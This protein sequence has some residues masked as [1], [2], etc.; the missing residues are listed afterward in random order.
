MIPPENVIKLYQDDTLFGY[1]YVEVTGQNIADFGRN[2]AGDQAVVVRSLDQNL[3]A[4]AFGTGN[5]SG[6][7][8]ARDRLIN[9]IIV[10]TLASRLGKSSFL[11]DHEEFAADAFSILSRARRENKRISITYVASDQMVHFR[12][13]GSPGYGTSVL[14]RVKFIAKLYIGAI[15]NAFMRN[16]IR[17]PEKLVWYLDVGADLDGSNAVQSFIRTI[18]QSEVKFSNL[19]DIT[20]TINHVGEFHDFYIP[21]Y[22]GERPVE[23]ET[24]NMGPAA[25]VDN[26]FLE[27]LRKA[28]IAGTG[29]PAAFLGYS[30]EI[31]F[32]RSLTMD[33]GRFLR[34]VIR[35]QKHYGSSATQV[36]QALWRN[37]YMTLEELVGGAEPASRAPKSAKGPGEAAASDAEDDGS[38]DQAKKPAG[39][40]DQPKKAPAKADKGK[41]A[42]ARELN[43]DPQFIE[44]RFPS[45]ATLNMDNIANA[46][47]QAGPVVDAIVGT[48]AD[49]DL[50][51][52]KAAY[53]QLV[54]EELVPQLHW[55][56][57]KAL[58]EEARKI[59]IRKAALKPPDQG[60]F[61]APADDGQE[62]G[63]PGSPGNA[64]G[65]APSQTSGEGTPGISPSDGASQES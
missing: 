30:E 61:G 12:P 64:A 34:R 21:T 35:H 42:D 49:G 43:I 18:K 55:D 44:V 52:T 6:P 9:R 50:D 63:D 15:T 65:T 51:E 57:F 16:S 54:T 62:A 47:N 2:T 33:N 31:A 1:Y 40:G 37:E 26:D 32:A 45:P 48:M 20:T 17:R 36:V 5:G 41:Q 7:E 58:L 11:A 25:E 59:G 14:S 29:V 56:R 23:V 24:L 8:N 10:K 27:Y 4:R 13:D 46:L 19:R 38:G 60:Q 39:S 22:N 53:K 3:A 28:I